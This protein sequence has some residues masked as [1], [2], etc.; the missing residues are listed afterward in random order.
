VKVIIEELPQGEEEVCI[1]RTRSVTDNIVRA[2]NILK[3][4][5]TLTVQN[6]HGS[7]IL[8]A[9]DVY[10]VESVELSTF[11]Y[12][13]SEIYTSKLRLYEAEQLLS[14]GD[15]LRI[16]KQ[17]ILN[18]AKIKEI[19]PAGGGRFQAELVNGEKVII[20]RSFVPLLKRRFGL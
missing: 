11:V 3:C 15:F 9:A 8:D 13:K 2:V 14:A 12:T 4:P 5:D 6:E 1:I 17:A 19:A 7:K 16:S 10:Y 20:A 18:V